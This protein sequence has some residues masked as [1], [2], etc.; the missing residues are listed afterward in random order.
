MC[1]ICIQIR[2]KRHMLYEDGVC[3]VVYEPQ[4]YTPHHLKVYPKQHA[5]RLKDL[6]REVAVH[7]FL[8]A[9][10]TASVAF[11][12]MHGHGTNIICN[13]GIL[14]KHLSIDI[15][16]RKNDD[17]VE[18]L[19]E[20][21]PASREKLDEIEKKLKPNVGYIGV[22]GTFTQE[23]KKPRTVL[24]QQEP[25]QPLRATTN[26]DDQLQDRKEEINYLIRNINRIP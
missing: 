5:L 26:Q 14:E 6:P 21:K 10:K 22:E 25:K 11:E 7:L 18:L 9:S 12:I 23:Q 4:G 8:V 3:A 17:G 13:D 20:P 15:L 19:W 1:D 16:T 2:K 24:P